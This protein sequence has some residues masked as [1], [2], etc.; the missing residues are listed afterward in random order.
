VGFV[1][2]IFILFKDGASYSLLGG[3]IPLSVGLSLL[4]YYML[5]HERGG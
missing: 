5:Q 1:L 2:T 4:A 3:L